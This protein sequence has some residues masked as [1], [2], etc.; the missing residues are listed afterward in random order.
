[1]VDFVM[2]GTFSFSINVTGANADEAAQFQEVSGL[3]AEIEVETVIEGGENHFV[4]KLP[5][6]AKHPNLVLKRGIAPK[7]SMLTT[8]F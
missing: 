2:P 6:S 1:M 7:K 5:K 3:E 4:H 8:W